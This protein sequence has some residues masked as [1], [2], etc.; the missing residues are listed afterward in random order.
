MTKSK[1]EINERTKAQ[2]IVLACR[3]KA[4]TFIDL[5]ERIEK[6]IR[7]DKNTEEGLR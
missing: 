5:A 2:E 1:E 3:N 6:K 4:K 7:Q